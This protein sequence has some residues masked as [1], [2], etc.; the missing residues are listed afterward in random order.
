MWVYGD[1]EGLQVKNDLWRWSFGKNLPD[2]PKDILETEWTVQN[3]IFEIYLLLLLLLLLFF[4]V[5]HSWLRIKSRGGPQGMFGHS[6]I[7]VK[8]YAFFRGYSFCQWVFTLVAVNDA[9]CSVLSSY[10]YRYI[11][12][13]L[14]LLVVKFLLSIFYFSF[15][16]W[17][18]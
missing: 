4:Q 1:L 16:T 8:A 15:C 14:I 5:S 12:F 11:S 9:G 13:C 3:Y 17:P 6:A 18:V 7:K 2:L 10:I